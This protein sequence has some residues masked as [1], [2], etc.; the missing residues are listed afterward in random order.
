MSNRKYLKPTA[1]V[2][3]LEGEQLCVVYSN[4]TSTGVV[5][6]MHWEDDNSSTGGNVP[7]MGWEKDADWRGYEQNP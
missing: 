1:L 5:P 3:P 6:G 2:V 4:G 7:G